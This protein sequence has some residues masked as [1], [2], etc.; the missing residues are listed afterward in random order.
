MEGRIDGG[1]CLGTVCD[2]IDL[3]LHIEVVERCDANE[4]F[5]MPLDAICILSSLN[6]E[7]LNLLPW[8]IVANGDFGVYDDAI[9]LGRERVV[10]GLRTHHVRIGDGHDIILSCTDARHQH[11]LLNDLTLRVAKTDEVTNAEGTHV[12]HHQS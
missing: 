12:G 4:R 10:R 6:E 3:I 2:A 9:T 7:R 5:G 11:A 1:E 8:F